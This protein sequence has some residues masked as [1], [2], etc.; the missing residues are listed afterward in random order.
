MKKTFCVLLAAVMLLCFVSC[1]DGREVWGI[2]PSYTGLPVTT[3]DR[4]FTKE[5]FMVMA[6]Y[7]DGTD[8][9]IDD[10]EFEVVGFEEGYYVIQFTYKDVS[11]PLYIKCEI[12]IYPSD[13]KD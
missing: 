7:A 10:Y 13:M 4:E 3:T 9:F 5:D 11:N 12:P 2:L 8:E 6:N 1:D